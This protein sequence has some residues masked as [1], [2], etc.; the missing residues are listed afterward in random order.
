MNILGRLTLDALP[1]DPIVAGGAAAMTAVSIAA[2]IALF[3]FK[4]WG[5]LWR[6]WLTTLDPKKIGVMYIVVAMA[7]L[8]RGPRQPDR[9]PRL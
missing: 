8:L 1:H 6:E 9:R 7:M 4:R 2:V 5:W 3:Y